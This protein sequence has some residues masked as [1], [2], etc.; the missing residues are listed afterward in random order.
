MAKNDMTPEKEEEYQ[1]PTFWKNKGKS[2]IHEVS[3][4][5]CHVEEIGGIHRVNLIKGGSSKWAKEGDLFSR[6][7]ALKLHIENMSVRRL[8]DVEVAQLAR[9]YKASIIQQC[10]ATALKPMKNETRHKRRCVQRVTNRNKKEQVTFTK[11]GRFVKA[12][13]GGPYRRR[14]VRGRKNLQQQS[15]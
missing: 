13:R 15:F 5:K 6:E 9:D 11:F 2:I 1:G 10:P 7:A 4:Q 8:S 3:D 12:A 14:N